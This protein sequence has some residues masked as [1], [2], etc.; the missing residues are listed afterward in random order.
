M[1]DTPI[2]ENGA[3]HFYLTSSNVP[4]PQQNYVSWV[5][6]AG[7]N[8]G[9]ILYTSSD[10]SGFNTFSVEALTGTV[11]V[12]VSV[13]GTNYNATPL[14][15]LLH[16]ATAS[17]TLSASITVGLIGTFKG[18]FK[19]FRVKQSGATAATARGSHGNI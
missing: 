2:I 15:I 11:I 7:V 5:G 1:R 19:S 6:V 18:K 8:T 4:F 12:E 9:D 13:D 14:A 17:T 16:N 3:A 10:I